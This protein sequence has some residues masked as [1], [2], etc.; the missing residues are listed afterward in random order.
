[1]ENRFRD[2]QSR[3]V[4]VERGLQQL[5]ADRLHL[6]QEAGTL[7]EHMAVMCLAT[8]VD[9]TDRAVHA[10]MSANVSAWEINGLLRV[11]EQLCNTEMQLAARCF[12]AYD[13]MRTLHVKCGRCQPK[14]SCKCPLGCALLLLRDLV[15]LAACLGRGPMDAKKLKA[16]LEEASLVACNRS[17][18]TVVESS[19]LT[20]SYT[21]IRLLG[22]AGGSSSSGRC[23]PPT[24]TGPT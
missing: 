5:L 17:D 15:V 6:E 19:Q 12:A 11:R 2:F 24:C 8:M 10:A 18:L 20:L 16:C 4:A 23:D 9:L 22:S 13:M 3:L 7:R 21:K 1:M 14:T